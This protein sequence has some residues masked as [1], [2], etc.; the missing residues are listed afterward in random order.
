MGGTPLPNP[1]APDTAREPAPAAA[2]AGN[3]AAPGAKAATPQPEGA[4]VLAFRD[5]SWTEVK[6]GSG[7]MLL[8]KMNAGGTR[9]ALSGTPPIELV[10]GNASDVTLTWKGKPVDLAPYTRQNIARLT[11]Q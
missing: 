7:R 3:A 1:M 11:L 8:S 10:I 5:F 9:E 2:P 6:D 4:I